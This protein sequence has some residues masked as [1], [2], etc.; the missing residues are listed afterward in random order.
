MTAQENTAVRD[1]IDEMVRRVV[2]TRD[3]DESLTLLTA[4]AVDSIPPVHY[5][6]ISH[7]VDGKPIET[8]APT[9]PL[10][11]AVDELQ[12]E[13]AEGPCFDVA[14][15]DT[16]ALSNDLASEA[17]WP[18]FGPRAAELGIGSQLAMVLLA[19]KRERAAV[20]L[21]SRDRQA[22][23]GG[24]DVAELF[25]AQAGLVMGFGRTIKQLDHA[26]GSRTVIGQAVG[27]L[28]ERY[29]I[30]QHQAFEYLTR[31]SQTTN[32]KLRIVAES[33]VREVSGSAHQ[34]TR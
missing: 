3:V 1:A 28:M 2:E 26:L 4:S 10:A 6:S 11:V 21:Y 19:E 23:D 13:L 9:H 5:A 15:D 27:I 14:L 7:R 18:R 12:Y 8:L 24:F 32:T 22:F 34:T 17:R 33:L 30:D 31:L 16:I 20:N 29:S 25:A